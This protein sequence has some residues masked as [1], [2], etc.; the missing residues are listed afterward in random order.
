[1]TADLILLSFAFA[2]LA[3]GIAH[4]VIAIKR[5]VWFWITNTLLNGAAVEIR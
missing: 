3:G 2:F 4:L 5:I 1:M